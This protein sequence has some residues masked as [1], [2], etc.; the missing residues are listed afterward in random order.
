MNLKD[1]FDQLVGN[2]KGLDPRLDLSRPECFLC[3][4]K[5]QRKN[6][7]HV[8]SG[9]SPR[10]PAHSECCQGMRAFDLM[11]RYWQAV[12][13]SITGKEETPNPSAPW[14]KGGFR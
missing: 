10:M 5:I 8:E 13:A 6:L 9:A 4:K 7:V 11:T 2:T 1:A 14:V 12:R 3:G